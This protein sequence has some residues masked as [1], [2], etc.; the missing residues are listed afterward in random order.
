MSKLSK[1]NDT[2]ARRLSS[3]SKDSMSSEAEELLFKRTEP[4]EQKQPYRQ[5]QC[6][7]DTPLAQVHAGFRKFLKEHTSPPNNRVTAGGRI[8]PVG[9]H[10][11]LPPSFNLSS[12][13][14][15]IRGQS[16]PQATGTEQVPNTTTIVKGHGRGRSSSTTENSSIASTRR[17]SHDNSQL[18][19][20]SFVTAQANTDLAP[21]YVPNFPT[22]LPAGAQ[23]LVKLAHGPTLVA[24]NNVL[25]EAISQ[26]VN[27]VLA[28]LN[29]F[30]YGAQLASAPMHPSFP[31]LAPMP[32]FPMQSMPLMNMTNNV[33]FAFNQPTVGVQR[34]AL[35]KQLDDLRAQLDQ[36]D[37]HVALHRSEIGSYALAGVVAQ[38]RQ[39]VVQID[40]TRVAKENLNSPAQMNSRQFNAQLSQTPQVFNMGGSAANIPGPYFPGNGP[41][42][43][44]GAPHSYGAGFPIHA[45]IPVQNVD[46]QCPLSHRVDSGGWK[47]HQTTRDPE[48]QPWQQ[49]SSGASNPAFLNDHT[50]TQLIPSGLEY[51][52][53][54]WK[55][56]KPTHHHEGHDQQKIG[57][58]G[59]MQGTGYGPTTY[60]FVSGASWSHRPAEWSSPVQQPSNAIVQGHNVTHD[61]VFNNQPSSGL[62]HPQAMQFPFVTEEEASYATI[63][64]INPPNEPKKYCSTPAEFAEAIR[65]A[66][67]QARLYG[68]VNW[69]ENN[70]QY[71]AEKD[72]RRAMKGR[73]RIPLAKAVPDY[74]SNPQPWDWEAVNPD[75]F[76]DVGRTWVDANGEV[77]WEMADPSDHGAPVD[78]EKEAL[79][80][81]DRHARLTHEPPL[82][83]ADVER[84]RAQLGFRVFGQERTNSVGGPVNPVN[85][86]NGWSDSDNGEL[87][88]Q[89]KH[90]YV[91][92]APETPARYGFKNGSVN[93]VVVTDQVPAL[94]NPW[95]LPNLDEWSSKGKSKGSVTSE[96]SWGAAG[97]L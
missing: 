45:G 13:A 86:Q 26:G 96:D 17:E 58:G 82:T 6:P 90:A 34:Q 59:N 57:A 64:G 46:A 38:R 36:L 29:G 40:Q 52:Q 32:M 56:K 15:V 89:L 35:Q 51:G 94:P 80:D 75:L 76:S 60:G 97:M 12:I 74:L 54:G 84:L 92:D 18:S 48:A 30:Q 47:A 39:L 25:F 16:Q 4:N 85:N 10:A 24:I 8:V 81:P 95:G 78:Y 70:P 83:Q 2:R 63:M 68:R 7:P 62:A 55:A 77:Q 22:P 41:P 50:A 91:E 42:P 21:G 53:D 31:M 27:T 66:R 71:H 1:R 87:I 67:D 23:V 79:A 5:P 14:D 33:P 73:E 88:R 20:A 37:K 28:P 72:I 93:G 43:F 3:D 61:P 9:L 44:A 65:Q 19:E 11:T 49:R 69:S